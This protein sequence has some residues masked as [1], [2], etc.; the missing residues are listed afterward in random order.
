MGRRR[1]SKTNALPSL[2]TSTALHLPPT[3]S[4]FD[5]KLAP[6]PAR[7]GLHHLVSLAE[8][9]GAGVFL[10]EVLEE[11][12]AREVGRRKVAAAKREADEDEDEDER[13]LREK[14]FVHKKRARRGRVTRSMSAAG[15]DAEAEADPTTGL[16]GDD[17]EGSETAAG[18]DEGEGKSK[19]RRR[20]RK[21]GMRRNERVREGLKI[22]EV[23]VEEVELPEDF[24]SDDLLNSLHAHTASLFRSTHSLLPPLTRSTPFLPPP[25][26]AH[27]DALSAQHDAAEEKAGLEGTATNFAAWKKTRAGR[28]G[29]GGRKGVWRDA[30]GAFEGSALVAMGMLAK[31]LAEDAVQQAASAAASPAQQAAEELPAPPPLAEPSAT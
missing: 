27:F 2:Y 23:E 6:L 31:L 9:G 1:P 29:M 24:P 3:A 13:E 14:G 19:R 12:Y 10:R 28:S 30:Q 18:G 26:R 22:P 8:H 16:E 17:E 11:S 5:P 20:S 4:H 7:Q 15:S 25:I 21:E